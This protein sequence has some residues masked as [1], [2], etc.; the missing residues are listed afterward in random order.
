MTHGS[1]VQRHFCPMFLFVV[2]SKRTIDSTHDFFCGTVV[3][4]V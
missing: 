1:L 3:D 4:I 2:S